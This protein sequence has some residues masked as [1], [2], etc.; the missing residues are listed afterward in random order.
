MKLNEIAEATWKAQ[1]GKIALPNEPFKCLR[2][3][4]LVIEHAYYKDKRV[5]Y[6]KYAVARTSRERPKLPNGQPDMDWFASDIEASAKRLGYAVKFADR[7]PGDLLFNYNLAA[8]Y[9]HV[10]VLIDV[11]TVLENAPRK[12]RKNS[13]EVAPFTFLTRIEDLDYSLIARF[14]RL[15]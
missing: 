12:N 8:P 11:N 13:L 2:L 3:A 5:F 7:Q 4:R 1:L 10:A 9:G 6:D 15:L 14:P